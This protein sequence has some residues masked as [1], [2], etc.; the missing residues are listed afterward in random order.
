MCRHQNTTRAL[1]SV[2]LEKLHG[3]LMLFGRRACFKGAEITAP[4]GFRIDLARVEAIAARFQLADH[5]MRPFRCCVA[6]DID[7][8]FDGADIYQP[9]RTCE[10]SSWRDRAG[11]T[12]R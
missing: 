7:A 11:R 8:R 12:S 6:V 2:P 3:A 9:H 4:P 1:A 10:C 5:S